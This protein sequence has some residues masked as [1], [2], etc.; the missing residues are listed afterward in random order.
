MGRKKGYFKN[1]SFF[2]NNNQ[3]RYSFEGRVL[4]VYFCFIAVFFILASRL[5]ALQ[6]RDYSQF[7]DQA[8]NIHEATAI[9][10]PQRGLIYCQ[11]KNNEYIPLAINKKYYSLYTVPKEIE[12]P[13][14][15]S[16]ILSEV[17]LLPYEEI[18]EKV[19]KPDDPYELI[20]KKIDDEDFIN[21]IE[22][23]KLEGVYFGEEYHRYYPFESFAAQTI[24]FVAEG[25]DGLIKG[26]Y[27][28]EAYYDQILEGQSGIFQGIKD[29]L[30][31]LVRS[32][33]SQE[34]KQ[35]EGISIE[36]T[37][38]KN[39]Q[40]ATQKALEDLMVTRKASKGTIIV[41]EVKTGKILALANWPIFNLNNFAEIT[42][43]SV[44]RNYAIEERYEPG[45]V[46]KPFTML[47][48]LDTGK[49]TPDTTYIDKGYYEIGGYRVENYRSEVHG[50]ST[51]RNVLE[52]SINTG[53]IFVAQQIGNEEL[54]KYFRQLGFGEITGID[55]PR[56]IAGDLSNLEYP[57][58]NPTYFATASYGSGISVTPMSLIRAYAIIA[59]KGKMVTPYLVES[60]RDSAGNQT[61][62]M[63]LEKLESSTQVVNEETAETL[64]SMLV[65]VIENGFGW[66]AKIKG[67]SLAGKTGTSFISLEE[68]AGYSEEEIHTFVG[69]FPAS[70]PEYVILVKMDRPQ[71]GE[72]AASQTVTLAFKEIERFLI[73]YY[74]IPPDEL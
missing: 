44:F 39:V 29:A 26:R 47:A 73:N 24:G 56:E 67:Y 63:S 21:Q 8:E 37:L 4:F 62:L 27:G 5:Y 6:I 61:S 70:D 17:T 16:E 10:T 58:V 3:N 52:F 1:R 65:G 23:K 33:F 11:D 34:K 20:L 40:F 36:T 43:Y 48:G 69:F 18:F 45:S 9:L 46:I 59:N 19:S 57:K 53:A 35:V 25:D 30:G 14:K 51:M 72:G 68:E 42:D 49:V 41:M 50:E 74:N 55:L 38:D 64:T 60:T 66:N 71:W 13:E 32:T 54:R 31:R 12:N 28:L 22:E 15:V 2:Q 7:S